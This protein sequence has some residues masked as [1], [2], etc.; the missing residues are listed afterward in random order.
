[1]ATHSS[2]FAWKIPWTQKAWTMALEESDTAEHSSRRWQ[3]VL[4]V[5]SFPGRTFY[6]SLLA[7]CPQLCQERQHV[8]RLNLGSSSLFFL[9]FWL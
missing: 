9:G 8:P 3:H 2:I 1:M 6:R 5:S 7:P 4:R